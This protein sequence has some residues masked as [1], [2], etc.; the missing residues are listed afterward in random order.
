MMP[1]RPSRSALLRRM[2]RAALVAASVAVAASPAPAASPASMADRDALPELVARL[3]PGVVNISILKQRARSDGSMPEGSTEMAPPVREIG[4][5]FIVDADG[6]VLTNRH[7]VAGAYKVSVILNDG[8]IEP[9]DVLSTNDRPDLA[10]LKINAGHKL[11]TVTWGDSDKLRMGETV[12]AI[13]NPLGLSS[14]ITVGVVSA[15]NRD[16]NETMID[17]FVQTDAAINHG[18]SGGPL[19]NMRG[20]VIG[21]NTQLISPSDSSG[22]I[23]LGLAIPANDATFVVDE[24]RKYGKLRAGFLGVRLQQLTSEIASTVGLPNT[25]GGIVSALAPDGP[26]SKA[27]L[28][29]GDV[30]LQFG[31]R[32]TEDIRAIL[33]E[34]G[35]TLPGATDTIRLWRDGKEMKVAVTLAEWPNNDLNPSGK[36]VMP[37][38]GER[39]SSPT[40]GM[41]VAELTPDLRHEFKLDDKVVGVI[42]LG[43]AANSVGAD[44]GFARGDVVLRVEDAKVLTI[45]QIQAHVA[46]A[47]DQGRKSVLML[48]TNDNRPHWL[49]VPTNEQ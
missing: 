33:R 47:R 22:S 38:R 5:G 36:E 31:D 44:V 30:I 34:I 28:R 46:T 48:V 23:G 26:A 16:V 27:G 43:V 4:S 35:G 21:I 10:L 1:C 32:A 3:L 42:V 24:M 40:L 25:H 18:N 29:E 41:R 7:V 12:I 8:T 6:F 14:S 45:Q 11:P 17:D 19:F 37:P 20:E 9:A 2:A 49:A 15:L 13:G 39:T